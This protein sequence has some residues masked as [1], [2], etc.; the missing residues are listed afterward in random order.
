MHGFLALVVTVDNEIEHIAVLRFYCNKLLAAGGWA[1]NIVDQRQVPI[2]CQGGTAI[3][4]TAQHT[5]QVSSVSASREK[6]P[7]PE[8]ASPSLTVM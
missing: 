3:Q 5:Q 7:S 6:E 4:T 8:P 1:A 2:R